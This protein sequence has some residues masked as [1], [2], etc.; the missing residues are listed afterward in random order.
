M[1]KDDMEVINI[2]PTFLKYYS[3][4]RLAEKSE[5]YSL[6]KKHYNFSAIPPGE[7]GEQVAKKMLQE[8]WHKYEQ[9][10]PTL[11]K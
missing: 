10:V 7:Q 9:V 8:A 5:R 6:W 4:A 2:V 1:E 11:E 3:L